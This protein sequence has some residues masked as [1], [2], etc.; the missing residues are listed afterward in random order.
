M[1]YVDECS[2]RAMQVEWITSY[3]VLKRNRTSHLDH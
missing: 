2:R 3:A 1:L